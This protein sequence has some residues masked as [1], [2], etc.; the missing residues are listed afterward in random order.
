MSENLFPTGHWTGFYTYVPQDRHRM[1]MHRADDK[2]KPKGKRTSSIIQLSHRHGA[3]IATVK[4]R[5]EPQAR[6]AMLTALR[7]LEQQVRD[8]DSLR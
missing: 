4:T 2:A 5:R 1:D 3:C 6:E 7:L 8:D